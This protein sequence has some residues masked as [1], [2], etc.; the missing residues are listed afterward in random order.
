MHMDVFLTAGSMEILHG[1][2]VSLRLAGDATKN[3]NM[4]THF[5]AV[6]PCH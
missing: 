4:T 5:N 2:Q 6:V 1:I 3:C